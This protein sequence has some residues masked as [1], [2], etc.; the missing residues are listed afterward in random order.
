MFNFFLFLGISCNPTVGNFTENVSE[1]V[2]RYLQL[3]EIY[4][5]HRLDSDT[6]GLL[7]LG[8]TYFYAQNFIKKRYKKKYKT[9]LTWRVEEN[10]STNR[11][12]EEGK[13]EKNS[14]QNIINNTL[15]K[16]GITLTHYMENTKLHPKFLHQIQIEDSKI[17]QSI[18][19]GVSRVIS[20]TAFEWD[21]IIHQLKELNQFVEL[22][23]ALEEWIHPYHTIY[24]LYRSTKTEKYLVSNIY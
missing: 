22:R 16:E 3:E 6:S 14:H 19:K 7:I 5:P 23:L 21:E 1:C 9:L 15:L 20:Y 11:E 17:C 12:E 13:D 10:I 18:I 2:K 24:D 8:K 4:L